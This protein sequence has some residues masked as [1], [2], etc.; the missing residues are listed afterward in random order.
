MPNYYKHVC[1]DITM[2]WV[3]FVRLHTVSDL[4]LFWTS[5]S[6][7]F[8]VRVEQGV[9]NILNVCVL[10]LFRFNICFF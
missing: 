9:L 10:I 8:L 4:D 2:D 7:S 5:L 1:A 6:L 3:L